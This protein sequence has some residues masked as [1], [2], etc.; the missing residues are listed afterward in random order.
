MNEIYMG[1]EHI[2]DLNGYDHMLYLLA[3]VAWANLADA[4]RVVIL[5][6]AFTLGHSIT[7]LLAGMGWVHAD[8]AWIEF[9]IPVTIT[10]TALW[11]LRRGQDKG[12]TRLATHLRPYHGLRIGPRTR[13]QFLFPDDAR[14]RRKHCNAVA[15][16]Q[17]GGGSGA[18]AD[19]RGVL[20]T[21]L[22]G[23]C[24]WSDA[25]EQQVFVC[26]VTG[27]VAFLMA[28]ERLPFEIWQR[29]P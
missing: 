25:R 26:A 15:A 7:L 6:T 16:L 20:G 12:P 29:P 3:L 27:T 13:L 2:T 11:N 10:A 28:V 24:G 23:T 21:G 9:L 17:L 18:I 4:W 1:V 5:A 14:R 8:G 19:T 22:L